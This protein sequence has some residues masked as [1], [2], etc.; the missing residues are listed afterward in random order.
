MN[1]KT[2]FATYTVA[3]VNA[4]TWE[5][6]F[7]ENVAQVFPDDQSLPLAPAL[8]AADTAQHAALEQRQAGV[9]HLYFLL[10]DGER[11]I[12]WHFGFQR[13][14]LEYF[15]AN[16]GVLPAYQGRGIYSAFLKFAVG[17][18]G[19]EGFQFITSIHHCDN[20]AVLVPKLK[21]GFLLQA[22]GY[23]IQPMLLEANHGAM[24]QLVYPVKEAFRPLF[25]ARVGG[26]ALNEAM[27]RQLPG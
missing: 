11:P 1:K 23:L 8:T 4:E 14:A 17:R 9:L 22:M 2:L 12:G 13:S 3:E 18:I 24:V 27:R 16:T 20:N 25:S 21:A 19:A 6:F 15:M 26:A 7:N 5:T 10:Y